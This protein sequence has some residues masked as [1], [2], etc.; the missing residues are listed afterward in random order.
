MAGSGST[1][2][3]IPIR[4]GNGRQ[5]VAGCRVVDA[6]GVGLVL[7]VH[8]SKGR[9][10]GSVEDFD[11]VSCAAALG[12]PPDQVRAIVKA[13][14]E[15]TK[16]FLERGRIV[17]WDERQPNTDGTDAERAHRYRER[18]KGTLRALRDVTVTSPSRDASRSS[19]DGVTASRD[20]VTRHVIVTDRDLDFKLIESSTLVLEQTENAVRNPQPPEE[21]KGTGEG[22][23]EAT[24]VAEPPQKPKPPH[25]ADRAELEAA[26]ARKRVQQEAKLKA[27]QAEIDRIYA[28]ATT[29]AKKS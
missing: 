27:R 13:L 14:E 20:F 15:G 21:S 6:L 28:I 8:A 12:M 23:P 19:R 18:K 17:D 11:P 3:S 25:M 10:R 26:D 22:N 16:P 29:G 2:A 4:S 1:R 7:L 5:L 24:P 9:P